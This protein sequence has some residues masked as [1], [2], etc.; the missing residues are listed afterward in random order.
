M[1]NQI[2]LRVLGPAGVGGAAPGGG[3]TSS[4]ARSAAAGANAPV[5]V[6]TLD[7][8]DGTIDPAEVAAVGRPTPSVGWVG[9]RR[10]V[11]RGHPRRGR[12][13]G[14]GRSSGSRP[15]AA[16]GLPVHL[17][18]ARLWNAAVASGTTVAERAAARH[19]GHLLPVEGPRRAGRL[20]AGRAGRPRS[21]RARVERKRL[22]GAMRQ[23]GVLAAAG[24]LALDR[25]DRLADDHARAQRLGHAAAE[26]LAGIG[27]SRRWC[28]PTSS[29][30]SVPD[31]ARAARS[32]SPA[33]AC[34][35]CPG[36]ATIVRLVT[37]ADVDDDDIERDRRRPG[38]GAV[39]EVDIPGAGARRL[40]PPRRP[41]GGLRRH[42]GPLGG[43]WAARCTWSSPTGATRGA[44]TPPPIPTRWP[45]SG[46]RR[47]RGA[48][49]VLGL[50]GVEHLGYPDGEIDND[51]VL[52]TPSHRDRAPAAARR[53]GRPPIPRRSSSATATSTTAT[54]ASSAG[55]CSTRSCRRPAR[56][57][58]PRPARRTRSAS[59][60]WPA[61]SRPTRGST[62]ATVL[63]RKVAAVAC[64]ESRLG[65][66]PALVA[67]LLEHRAVER[68]RPARHA[69][70]SPPTPRAFSPPAALPEL[71]GALRRACSGVGEPPL[72]WR[73]PAEPLP[74]RRRV[75]RRG[76]RVR[77]SPMARRARTATTPTPTAPITAPSTPA[78]PSQRSVQSSSA[79]QVGEAVADQPAAQ[80]RR[81]GSRRRRAR[82]R[83]GGQR[84]GGV[85]GRV[86]GASTMARPA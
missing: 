8:A 55:P 38:G 63:D 45:S 53:A 21:R 80:A 69:R 49:A 31:P 47:W 29:A 12:A 56:S 10:R 68:Q 70:P 16:V 32:T 17:D 44:P 6:V 73:A 85:V 71:I 11:R 51:A 33:A 14:S 86:G 58:C 43:R 77:H 37:H 67:E 35:P 59:C 9:A 41:R 48:A 39:I 72:A 76:W 23:V 4:C 27:R 62:S 25:V 3:S 42:A 5:Q 34:W 60:C 28:R 13:A 18:G 1:A 30:S 81:R 26:P 61:R 75:S 74:P 2:A 82:G 54:T 20:A 46:P 66:D 24:L 19:H 40:R 83:R 57:T 15:S 22:G 64:H 36:S 7:D 50:A 65:G 79:L 78:P 52:R 84:G